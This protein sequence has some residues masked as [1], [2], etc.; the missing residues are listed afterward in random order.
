MNALLWILGGFIFSLIVIRLYIFISPEYQ[1]VER[2]SLPFILIIPL[3][4][5]H[6]FA[7]FEIMRYIALG[8]DCLIF[9]LALFFRLV[10]KKRKW[11]QSTNK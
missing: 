1:N 6:L 5:I 11:S 7:P 10:P 2:F 9:L 8:L 4:I 3:V